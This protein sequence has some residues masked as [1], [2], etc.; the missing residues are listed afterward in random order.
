MENFMDAPQKSFDDNWKPKYL[1]Y[2]SAALIAVYIT[3]NVIAAKQ[4]EICGYLVTAGTLTFPFM[5]VLGDIISEI[6]GYKRSRQ[7]IFCGFLPW[8]FL[9]ESPRWHSCCQAPPHGAIN[10]PMK[11]Y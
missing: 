7:I 3:T 1:H 6:Y 8:S 2:L 5:L 10:P 9:L 11:Q 4:A